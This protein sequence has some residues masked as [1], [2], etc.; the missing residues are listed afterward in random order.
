MIGQTQRAFDKDCLRN[1]HMALVLWGALHFIFDTN[2]SV[3]MLAQTTLM[4]H[5]GDMLTI[6]IV[7]LCEKPW[8]CSK[9]GM[10]LTSLLLKGTINQLQSIFLSCV[11]TMRLCANARTI[12]NFEIVFSVAV[13]L[14]PKVFVL[15]TLNLKKSVPSSW[16]RSWGCRTWLLA[17]AVFSN[18][19]LMCFCFLFVHLTK[20]E[21][22]THTNVEA[23]SL[24]RNALS[25]SLQQCQC[26]PQ[27][28][29]LLVL[30]RHVLLAKSGVSQ[31]WSQ[32]CRKGKCAVRSNWDHF[33]SH[34]WIGK[35]QQLWN[36]V[37]VL[38][39][40]NKC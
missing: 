12:T 23:V 5:F 21:L 1:F 4:H 33:A 16:S 29:S 10:P 36:E 25:P 15:C 11:K 27:T 19:I 17:C 6:L 40:S 32:P 31:V 39:Q 26:E 18:E 7:V 30:S 9:I 28:V 13:C 20:A 37:S 22:N 38:L 35:Q 14:V 3:I 24:L 34:L 8:G 2:S